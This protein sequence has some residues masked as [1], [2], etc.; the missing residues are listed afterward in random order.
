MKTRFLMTLFI[1]VVPVLLTVPSAQAHV[2]PVFTLDSLFTA[3]NTGEMDTALAA[4]AADA[5]VENRMWGET[6]RGTAEIGPVLEAMQREGRQYEIVRVEMV[7]DTITVAVDISDRGQVWGTETIMA[8]VSAGKLQKLS[9][10][11]I[12]LKL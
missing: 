8:E 2:E 7:G 12:Q 6:Y 11:A 9:V 5:L 10:S 4:F 3:L 1:L